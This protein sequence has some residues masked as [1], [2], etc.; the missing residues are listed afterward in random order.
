M[1]WTHYLVDL[2]CNWLTGNERIQLGVIGSDQDS[3]D[4]KTATKSAKAATDKPKAKSNMAPALGAYKGIIVETE[5]C[6]TDDLKKT[7]RK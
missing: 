7:I 6:W 1:N 3:T 4:M 5:D 2:P